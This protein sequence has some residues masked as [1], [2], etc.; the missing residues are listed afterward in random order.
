MDTSVYLT[1]L[2]STVGTR[3]LREVNE[4]RVLRNEQFGF[5]S[6]HSTTLQLARLFE[7]FNRNFD[8][9]KLT[10]ALFLDVANSSP[11][12][13]TGNAACPSG[14]VCCSASTSSVQ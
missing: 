8:E 11:P 2:A 10:V 6:R 14:K 3:V 9:K 7:I 13:L 4:R 1:T 5:R 12:S